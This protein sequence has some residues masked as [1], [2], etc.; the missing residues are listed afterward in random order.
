MSF[1]KEIRLWIVPFKKDFLP[2][3]NEEFKIA[4]KLPSQRSS[5]YSLTRGY[6]RY[7]LSIYLNIPALEIPLNVLPGKPPILENGLG[8][9]SLSHCKDAL[10]IGWAQI[11]LGVDIERKDRNFHARGIANKFF[12]PE[13]KFFLKDMD[14]EKY[15]FN[16]LKYWVIK[17]SAIKW[18]RGNI[19]NDLLY[20][21]VKD[22]FQLATNDLLNLNLKAYFYEFE[23]WS[24][25]LTYKK[26]IK[27][28]IKKI[29][30]KVV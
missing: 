9:I 30:T 14:D 5:Q 3:T 23:L 29:I 26:S 21:Q 24:I 1:D 22:N 28:K 17:E 11:K 16:V 6:L 20:W 13:E 27:E 4:K 8:E 25:G 7:V 18:Q 19:S 12:S 15:R 10:L 2:I